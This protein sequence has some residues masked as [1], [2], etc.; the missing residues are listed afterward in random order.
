MLYIVI[1]GAYVM[2][3]LGIYLLWVDAVDR[4]SKS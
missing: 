2:A 1:I 3:A 4:H